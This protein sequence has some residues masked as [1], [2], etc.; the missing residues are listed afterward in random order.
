MSNLSLQLRRL[1]LVTKAADLPRVSDRT[2]IH[3]ALRVRLGDTAT[4][5][6]KAAE[7]IATRASPRSSLGKSSAMGLL[8]ITLLGGIL[9]LTARSQRAFLAQANLEPS[10]AVTASVAPALTFGGDSSALSSDL[11][12]SASAMAADSVA[13]GDTTHPT[14]STHVRDRRAEAVALLSRA[15]TALHDANPTLALEMLN[16][17]ER[18]FGGVLEKGRIAARVQV[19]CALG[20]SAEADTQLAR[21]S[22]NSLHAEQPGHACRSHKVP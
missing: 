2:R 16:E 7:V 1:L 10:V 6:A 8:G 5:G 19:L 18:K 17:H 9:F 3:E 20:R 14:V 12:A 11:A 4:M 15:K 22:S 21:L 13:S